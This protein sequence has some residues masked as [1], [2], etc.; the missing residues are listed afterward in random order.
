MKKLIFIA[1]N[2]IS[3]SLVAQNLV[4][5]VDI[6]N[7]SD[8]PVTVTYDLCHTEVLKT[9]SSFVCTSKT[10]SLDAKNIGTNYVS[11]PYHRVNAII[12]I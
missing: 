3:Y 4:S 8:I 2:L 7:N 5:T 10:V 11:S 12:A 6:I 1:L 9:K